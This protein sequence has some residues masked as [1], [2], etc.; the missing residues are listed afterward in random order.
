MIMNAHDARLKTESAIKEREAGHG[1]RANVLYHEI[2]RVVELVADTGADSVGILWPDTTDVM[3][4]LQGINQTTYDGK[5]VL[6]VSDRAGLYI[7]CV[8][9]VKERLLQAGF[10]VGI[11]RTAD[12]APTIHKV[13]W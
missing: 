5:P 9:D 7:K 3:G 13:S 12:G 1:Q 4:V 2:L 11:G 6:T 8:P 10:K